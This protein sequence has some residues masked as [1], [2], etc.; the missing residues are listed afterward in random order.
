[1]A[2][3][4]VLLVDDHRILREG[5]RSLL[6]RQSG[7]KVVGEAADG[8]EA[9]QKVE[10]LHPDVVVMDIA[11]PGM[12]GLEATVRIKEQHPETHVLVLT[13]YD[14]QQFVMPLLR[15]GA[16]GY[17]LKRSGGKEILRAI[18]KVVQ[19]GAF[20][21][22]HAAQQVLEAMRKSEEPPKPQLTPRETEVL[23]LIAEGKTNKEIAAALGIS[24]KT[25]SVHR[26]NIMSKLDLH[27]SVE[28][29]RY[30]IRRGLTE[31]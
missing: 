26:S 4:R 22:P 1:V 28:L 7:I 21:H 15:A 13:Q 18:R 31:P 6:E 30:A 2:D 16:S 14:E 9:I 27:S 29:A 12:D 25:V 5:L 11:M 19:E 3:I 10:T 17:V 23:R 20:L 24:P 8:L